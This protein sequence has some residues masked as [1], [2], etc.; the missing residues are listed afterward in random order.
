MI[1]FEKKLKSFD[2]FFPQNYSLRLYFVF[3]FFI[4]EF[5]F[6]II[7]FFIEVVIAKKFYVF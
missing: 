3:V 2:D 4:I 7:E 1:V 6:K 5:E